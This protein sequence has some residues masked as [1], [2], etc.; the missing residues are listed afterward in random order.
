MAI[1]ILITFVLAALTSAI[2]TPITIK[3]AYKVG[4]VDVP[5]DARRIH[6]KAM[7]RIGGLAFILGFFISIIYMLLTGGIDNTTNLSGFFIGLAIIASVGFL[8]DVYQLK[9]WQKLIAQ[10]V[11]AI[12]VIASGLRICYIN[13]PFLTLYGLNDVLSIIITFGWIIGVTNAL[14]LIDG[15]D[16]LAT[17]V[18]AISTLA[19]SVI[20]ILNGSGDLPLILTIALLGGLVGFLP[21]NFNPAKTFMGDVGSNSLGFIL[22]TVSMIGMAKTYTFMAIILPVV[23]LGLPIFDTLFAIFRRVSHHKSI[24]EADRGHLHHKLID[25]GLTQ[26]QAVLVLYAVTAV[27]GILAVVILESS[28]WKVIMLV[29]ILAVLSVL[30]SKNLLGG[31][32]NMIK[33]KEVREVLNKEKIK[34]MVVFGTRPEAIKMCPLVLKLREHEEIE[35]VVCVT[36]QHR[37]MLDQVLKAF[38]IEPEY[39]LNVMKDKQTLTHITSAVLEGLYEVINKEKPDLI[40]VHGDTTTTFSAALASFYCKTKV[41]HVEAGLRTYDKYSPYPEEMNRRL[42]TN[43]A[44]LYFAPTQNNKHNLLKEMIEEGTIYVTG[45]TVIDALKTTVKPDYTFT[46]P[47]LSKIDFNKKVIFMTAHRRENL[48]EPL[49]NICNAVKEIATKFKDVEVVYPVHLNP[50]VQDV[51]TKTLGEVKNV[52]LVEPLDVIITHNL[53]N[54]SY[55]VMTDSGGIQE[56][57]PSLGKPVLV[58]RT[59]T[60]RPEAVVAG[61]VKIVGTDKERIIEEASKLLTDEKEYAKMSKAAN[62]YGDGKACERIVDAILYYFGKSEKKPN[63]L[64]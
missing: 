64:N 50:A 32:K 36:A 27:L 8:D 7:P 1:N 42:V 12:I 9:A 30:G 56:E 44:D 31:K 46:H 51:A 52:H 61:T 39:D 11:A 60:E 37:Q 18:S 17:G 53:I 45:N 43:L 54:K 41:G 3:L 35:T 47:I 14:N 19:L 13:I 33:T 59:E 20:F 16:G 26:K 57:A 38:K 10:I 15:L 24:M 63:D 21:Y 48:G 58:L 2:L 40:L 28:V 34:V 5:K 62:P 4:A 25:A 55:M 23:I 49:Q 29:A 6:S 22:A